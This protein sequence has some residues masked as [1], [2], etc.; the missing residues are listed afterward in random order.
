[1]RKF[2]RHYWTLQLSTII[3]SPTIWANSLNFFLF[4]HF[5]LQIRLESEFRVPCW[6]ATFSLWQNPSSC[7][8]LLFQKLYYES[9]AIIYTYKH[10]YNSKSFSIVNNII[11]VCS[12]DGF[13]WV[14]WVFPNHFFWRFGSRVHNWDQAY[15]LILVWFFK[16]WL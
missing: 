1:M 8:I 14:F 11:A 5:P 12:P 10:M 2:T 13:A 3:K 6:H 9:R 15:L 4:L 7:R 16:N